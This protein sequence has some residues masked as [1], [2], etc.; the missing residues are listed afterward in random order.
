MAKGT[1]ENGNITSS[2]GRRSFASIISNS[3]SRSSAIEESQIS[4]LKSGIESNQ[5]QMSDDSDKTESEI[6]ENSQYLNDKFKNKIKSK[7]TECRHLFSIEIRDKKQVGRCLECQKLIIMS[8]NSDAN[9]R[10]HLGYAHNKI[11]FLTPAQLKRFN[12]IKDNA[13]SQIIVE[14]KL[15]LDELVVDA[16]IQDSRTFNDFA[17]NGIKKVFE[18]L[19]PGYKPPS[20]KRIRKMIKTK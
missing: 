5:F 20:K 19:K 3:S 2:R 7:Y 18:F 10:T 15:K 4:N 14:E 16:I 9:L 13:N 12:N 8:S 1:S 17:K 11:E 6:D